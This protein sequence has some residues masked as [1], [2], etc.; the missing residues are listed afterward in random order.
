MSIS[1]NQAIGAVVAGVVVIGGGATAYAMNHNS[2]S[3]TTP[4]TP[5]VE[6][7]QVT[8]NNTAKKANNALKQ[9]GVKVQE[10]KQ[11]P[12]THN[13]KI[14]NVTVQQ[15]AQNIQ[16]TSVA[17]QRKADFQATVKRMRAEAIAKSQVKQDTSL[18]TNEVTWYSE[19]QTGSVH[20]RVTGLNIRSG[21]SLNSPVIAS[22]A[23]GSN[24]QVLG[25][26]GNWY[27]IKTSNG[28]TGFV[29]GAFLNIHQVQQ[30]TQS[31]APVSVRPIVNNHTYEAPQESHSESPEVVHTSTLRPSANHDEHVSHTS[32]T[33]N[34]A[35]KPNT[36]KPNG[37]GG[38]IVNLPQPAQINGN[39]GTSQ[40]MPNIPVINTNPGNQGSGET[41]QPQGGQP[42]Q[43]GQ[44]TPAPS[45]GQ[46]NKSQHQVKP[47]QP[48]QQ[49]GQAH[50][51][52][53]QPSDQ[54]HKNDVKP[55]T[56]E[57]QSQPTKH[58]QT[59]QGQ[60]GHSS[61]PAVKPEQPSKPVVPE[62]HEDVQPQHHQGV[63]P[64]VKPE[65][66]QHQVKP[67]QSQ[68]G[69]ENNNPQGGKAEHGQSQSGAPSHK[70][71]AKPVTPNH[72]QDKP[73]KPVVTMV[74]VTTEIVSS[75]GTVLVPSKTVEVAK[76]NPLDLSY[77][78]Q[79]PQGYHI[80]KIIVNGIN[81]TNGVHGDIDGATKIVVTVTPNEAVKPVVPAH[82][83]DVKPL[84]PE[85]NKDHN[86]SQGGE[87][88]PN[89]PA[90]PEHH[91]DAQP[92][93]PVK[94][95]VKYGTIN[96]LMKDTQGNLIGQEQTAKGVV[97]SADTLS[98]PTI[99]AGYQEV[100]M[101]VNGT[102]VNSLPSKFEAGTQNVVII[103]KKLDAPV[104]VVFDCNGTPLTTETHMM[105][106][107]S[108]LND[109]LIPSSLTK[110]YH[111]TSV[112]V[113]GQAT[114]KDISG[115]V[116]EGN[117][118]IVV[119]VAK[120]VVKPTGWTA[121]SQAF[122][123]A[124]EQEFAT[125]LANQRAQAGLSSLPQNADANEIAQ[126]WSNHLEKT[127]TCSDISN[128]PGTEITDL[129]NKLGGIVLSNSAAT[130]I[131]TTT[132]LTQHDAD[133][134]AQQIFELWMNSPIHRT[135]METSAAKCYGFAFSVNQNGS[136]YA[137]MALCGVKVSG[138]NFG[139]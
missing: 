103:V 99:P 60:S 61:K 39:G 57:H 74:P 33:G 18:Q 23:K 91:Q 47:E 15:A 36:V 9:E 20:T 25:H 88:G 98:M 63:K 45:Q 5:N 8:N 115:T 71:D 17:T 34:K 112:T 65:Q 120:N 121:N 101:T 125:L 64:S 73:S 37:N 14:G 87:V 89:Q 109:S 3:T 138:I 77:I 21:A 83:Q 113:N 30:D 110:H 67:E 124:V 56:P 1:K 116:Q 55:A 102:T 107:G 48:A 59:Q 108:E 52:D 132:G 13:D 114:G 80:T 44:N 40:N 41:N 128:N 54:G 38:E 12:I 32:S 31:T 69:Q 136:V 50:K 127:Q 106:V 123:Q 134:L 81:E 66:P 92:T 129:G 90:Q 11:A 118:V 22:V 27:L 72:N 28:V 62:H 93:K 70:T 10:A 58:D 43:G 131:R 24:L 51:G 53:V 46:S 79:I 85:G 75:N 35:V 76:G 68:S 26:D 96:I 111:V 84:Q 119:N 42:S 7:N 137:T 86:E 29:D 4:N 16:K 135:T 78:P 139:N 2:S 95:V 122:H 6:Q 117:N 130:S 126:L 82:H 100:S 133:K 94:P 19:V 49:G 97:G 104:K 105:K